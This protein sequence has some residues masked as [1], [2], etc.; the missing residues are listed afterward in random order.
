[1]NTVSFIE[2]D[3]RDFNTPA[4]HG[5]NVALD[6]GVDWER[7]DSAAK[8][9]AISAGSNLRLCVDGALRG[10]KHAAGGLAIFAYPANGGREL[11]CR[12][13]KR[14]GNLDSAFLAEALSLEWALEVLITTF[15]DK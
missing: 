8:D 1:M 3:G 12:A 11:L 6:T 14:F 7:S 10:G 4:D 5:A 13:G 9:R 15:L 2:W